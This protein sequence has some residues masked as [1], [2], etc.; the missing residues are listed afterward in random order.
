MPMIFRRVNVMALLFS[1]IIEMKKNAFA[2][3]DFLFNAL[4]FPFH[5]AGYQ[6]G[7]RHKPV[8]YG[9]FL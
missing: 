5:A 7:T 9:S 3:Y 6:Q 8:L 2:L 1:H 4:V